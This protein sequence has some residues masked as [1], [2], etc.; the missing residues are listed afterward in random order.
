[1]LRSLVVLCGAISILG[2][3]G[4]P[5]PSHNGLGLQKAGDSC[6]ADRDCERGLACLRG[7]CVVVEPPPPPPPP[8]PPACTSDPDCARGEVCRDGS[9]VP[10]GS[11]PGGRDCPPPP[12]PPACDVFAQD[13]PSAQ[14]CVLAQTGDNVCIAAGGES[15]GSGCTRADICRPGLAC[16]A[17][18]GTSGNTYYLSIDPVFLSRGGGTCLALC[19]DRVPCSGGAVCSAIMSGGTTRSDAGVCY[20]P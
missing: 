14:M 2:C 15:Q 18:A 1:M 20:T 8:P 9:C 7:I 6:Q 11:C 12:P 10:D 16:A 3:G 5:D 13:C 4:G 17:L 19:S